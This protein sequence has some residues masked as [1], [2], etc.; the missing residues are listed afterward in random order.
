MT[1]VTV[2]VDFG[3]AHT[4][5][6]AGSPDRLVTVAPS[7]VL[8]SQDDQLVAGHE[9][10]RLAPAD[11][12][13]LLTRL[14]TRLDEREVLVGDIVLPVAGLV[15]ALLT[16]AVRAVD[17]PVAE[18]VLTHP[19]DWPSARVAVLTQAAAGLAERVTTVAAPVAAAA[20][21]DPEPGTSMLVLDFGATFCA[22]AVVRRT[23]TGYEVAA[24]GSLPLG[25]DD[26]DDRVFDFL[27]GEVDARVRKER[28]VD[29]GAAD[30]L[31]AE[32]FERLIAGDV[33]RIVKMVTKVPGA[34]SVDRVLLVGGSSRVPLV[35]R[36]V[37]DAV[38]RPVRLAADPEQAVAWGAL[39]LARTER[40]EAPAA[41]DEPPPAPL[42]PVGRRL[43]VA[44]AL[45]VF[46]LAAAAVAVVGVGPGQLVAGLPG[47]AGLPAEA[48]GDTELPPE[49]AGQ[50]LV[51]AGQTKFTAGRLDAPVRLR[52]AS[53]TTLELTLTG[54]QAQPR[55]AAPFADA[56]LGYRWVT[57]QLSGA[58]VDGPD[59]R[60]DLDG[61]VAA[62]DDRGQ[63]IR[64][65]DGAVVGCAEQAAVPTTVGAGE[66]FA[67][68]VLLPVPEATPVTSVVFGEVGGPSPPVRFP[69][70][71]PP[72]SASAGPAPARAVGRL[73]EP[74]VEV[75]VDGAAVRAGFHLVLTPS[76]YLGD[77][78]PAPGN[79]YVVVRAQLPA[80]STA[81]HVYLRD[82][83][84]VLTKPLSGF[85]AMPKCPAFG[86]LGDPGTLVYAC[87]V[88]ELDADAPVAGVTLGGPLAGAG[89]EVDG[90]PTWTVS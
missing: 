61:M 30:G 24:S 35:G 67:A 8:L 21:A 84:G 62:L 26:L 56:P 90:W 11:P 46:V 34:A 45:L 27:G 52:Q 72:A 18:L 14:K 66:S 39:R 44:A 15:R 38:P 48:E 43:I 59:W 51:S 6:V 89:R 25:G 55:V 29:T 47:P 73:G 31:T 54:V 19:H 9:A 36:R 76:G 42:R 16:T 10:M 63:W 70:S 32:D 74:A 83:R 3:S 2:V 86:G 68:C 71:V 53:G 23:R 69:V 82:D 28:V 75:T 7:V 4:V 50:E 88:Y 78:R 87:F 13:R 20:G 65:F 41:A 12:S 80:L 49:V 37:A 60:A 5:V 85:D 57:A 81:E 17:G 58:N 77:R 1:G 40:V 22:A 79:R 33:A 64:P